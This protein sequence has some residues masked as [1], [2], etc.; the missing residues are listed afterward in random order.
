MTL[1]EGLVFIG[2]AFVLGFGLAWLILPR[3][4]PEKNARQ[5]EEKLADYQQNMEQHLTKTADL[6]DELTADY[7]KVHDHLSHSART[8]LNEEQLQRLAAQRQAKGYKILVLEESSNVSVSP[9]T[10]E[11]NQTEAHDSP[12]KSGETASSGNKKGTEPPVSG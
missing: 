2:L 10:N 5:L 1:T 12:E 3:S 9:H 6:L 4:R 11:K 7:K 8:L